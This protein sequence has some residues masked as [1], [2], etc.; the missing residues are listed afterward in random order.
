MGG[1]APSKIPTSIP[2]SEPSSGGG[3]APRGPPQDDRG[4]VGS[5]V[6]LL[7]QIRQGTKLKKVTIE[8][9]PDV[10]KMDEHEA[11]SLAN[12]IARAMEARRKVVVES[13]SDDDDDDWEL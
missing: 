4:G 6:D 12:N 9:I 7:E 1:G 3:G 10:E 8:D 13:E 11:D 5:S 2:Q